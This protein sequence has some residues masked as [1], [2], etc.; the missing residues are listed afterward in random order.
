MDTTWI[1]VDIEADG[2]VPHLYSMICF[3]AVAMGEAETFVEIL[4]LIK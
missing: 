4:K 1:V 3:G 2:Q